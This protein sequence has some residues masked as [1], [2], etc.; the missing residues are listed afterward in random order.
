MKKQM[1]RASG[2]KGKLMAALALLSVNVHAQLGG[3]MPTTPT[4]SSGESDNFLEIAQGWFADGITVIGFILAAVVFIYV[5]RNVM[6]AYADSVDGRGTLAGV[7]TQALVGVV[8]IG[9]VILLVTE[10]TSIFG[11]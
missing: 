6:S 8:I 7:F 5:A 2:I 9:L 1:Q 4:P 11:A 10:A 3:E